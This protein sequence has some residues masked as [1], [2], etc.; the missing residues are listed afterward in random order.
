MKTDTRR[1]ILEYIKKN[2]QVS[3]HAVKLHTGL[4]GSAIHKQLNK[5][6][7]EHAI[8]KIGR[9]PRVYYVAVDASRAAAPTYILPKE[10]ADSIDDS[11][12]YVNPDG[13][14]VEGVLGFCMWAEK[15]KQ[16][17]NMLALAQEYVAIRQKAD[18]WYKARNWIDDTE[19][20]KQTFSD[21]VVDLVAYK[22]FYALPKFGKTRLGALTL[23]A[24]VSQSRVL[25]NQIVSE[26]REP[27]QEIINQYHIEAVAFVPHSVPRMLPFLTVI[28]QG[29]GLELPEIKLEK[30]YQGEV[31]VAQKSLGK[32][33]ERVENAHK[34]IFLPQV[35]QY[36]RILLIDDAVGSG[37]TLNEVS[38]KLKEAQAAEFVAG[39]AVVGSY[40]GFEVIQ[41]V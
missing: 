3:P 1:N 23:H 29:L 33:E 30:I 4:S 8:Q 18:Q 14:L 38:K 26:I 28:K 9:P 21:S 39:F 36:T 37:A 19:K 10:I 20:L 11:Y 22:D 15:T 41:E 2:K 13:V 16:A 6:E 12:L 34:T 24:K 7:A 5:L 25:M 17:T 32:L 31:R 40:K 27:I 35:T